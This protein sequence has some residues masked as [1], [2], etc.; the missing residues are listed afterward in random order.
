M[1]YPQEPVP[2]PIAVG[3]IYT[4]ED[5]EQLPSG[6]RYELI[7]GELCALPANSAEHG[8]LAPAVFMHFGG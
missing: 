1:R 6:E 4:A 2:Q 3:E 8:K 7:R 5:L